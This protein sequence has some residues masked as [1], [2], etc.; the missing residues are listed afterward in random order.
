[1]AVVRNLLIVSKSVIL[2][3]SQNA[4]QVSA[5]SGNVLAVG[6]VTGSVFLVGSVVIAGGVG[7][8]LKLAVFGCF[9]CCFKVFFTIVP[10]C[11][12][13][14]VLGHIIS[15]EQS[16]DGSDGVSNDGHLTIV[17]CHPYHR[18]PSSELYRTSIVFHP[19]L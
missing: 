14:S 5:F 12:S 13:W 3:N 15:E 16:K 1:M 18:P 4:C 10:I 19:L 9:G 17:Q 2:T 7:V 6:A 11:V 8:S